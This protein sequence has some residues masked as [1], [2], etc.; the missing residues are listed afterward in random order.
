MAG[1]S[2]KTKRARLDDSESEDISDQENL[3][4]CFCCF[5]SYLDGVGDFWFFCF[6]VKV[7]LFG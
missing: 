2:K 6:N 1:G 7:N 3:K 5:V 4:V